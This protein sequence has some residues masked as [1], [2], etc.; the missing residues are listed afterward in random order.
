MSSDNKACFE[1]AMIKL[2]RI[3][4]LSI[5]D[6]IPKERLDLRW[7]EFCKICDNEEIELLKSYFCDKVEIVTG[8]I[9]LISKFKYI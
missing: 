9:L 4:N 8:Y 5:P 6:G 3:Q 7:E 2:F 1:K